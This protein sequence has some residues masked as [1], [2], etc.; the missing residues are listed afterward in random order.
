MKKATLAVALILF[1]VPCFAKPKTQ[2]YAQPCSIVFPVAEKLGSQP[3]Y[4]IQ[5]DA[6]ADM[7]LIVETGSFWKAGARQII[8]RFDPGVN[9]SCTVTVS[10]P[11]SGVLR[12]GTVFLDR[13][14][15]AL[16]EPKK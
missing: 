13:L 4:K 12:N 1:T 8:V 10:A 16:A 2:T 14:E 15:K 9:S 6:K 11:Y 5:L 3:P 7:Q